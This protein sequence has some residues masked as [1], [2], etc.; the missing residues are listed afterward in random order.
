MEENGTIDAPVIQQADGQ[1]WLKF[2]EVL[3]LT[4]GAGFLL[5]G[6]I[7]FFAF[8]WEVIHRFAKMGIVLALLLGTFVALVKVPMREW[9]R[10]ITI[11][12][13]CVL[14]GAFLAVFGQVY[15]TGADN[16]LLFLTWSLCIIVWVAVADFYPLWIFFMGLVMLTYGLAPSVDARLVDFTIILALFTAFF[17][18]SPRII[19][20]KS[21]TPKWVITF[22]FCALCVLSVALISYFIFASYSKS[23]GVDLFVGIVMSVCVV[24][25]ALFKK[26]IV[27]Y[28]LF[29]V[30]VLVIVFELWFKIFDFKNLFFDMFLL[31]F[32]AI[33]FIIAAF[34]LGKYLMSM[35]EKWIPK[36]LM[37]EVD[38]SENKA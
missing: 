36:S 9:V 7:F 23:K 16:Y 8:N 5:C 14:V 30:G 10:N 6:I 2:A 27:I 12:A 22:L 15:Q 35:K 34:L 1:K 3:T 18:F 32:S 26:N 29:C 28:S 11:F 38:E 31:L 19:P 25:Y 37:K 20:N 21:V 24:S 33:F 13:M 17:E 4:L